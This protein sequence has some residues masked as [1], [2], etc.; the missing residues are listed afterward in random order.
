MNRGMV[1]WEVF[2]LRRVD[3]GKTQSMSK[4]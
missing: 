2:M 1:G 3:I 4:R